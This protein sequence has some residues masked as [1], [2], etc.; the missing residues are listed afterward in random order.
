MNVVLRVECLVDIQLSENCTLMP[1]KEKVFQYLLLV[2][3]VTKL[4]P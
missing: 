1:L 4:V 2:K 3:F